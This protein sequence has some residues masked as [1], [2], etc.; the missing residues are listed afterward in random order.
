MPKRTPKKDQPED[1][2]DRQANG[3]V[4]SD[5]PVAPSSLWLRYVGDGFIE[6]VPAQDHEAPTLED[7]RARVASGLYDFADPTFAA[8][9][10]RLADAMKAEANAKAADQAQQEAAEA[11]RAARAAA[12]QAE[13]RRRQADAA[14]GR[15]QT[16]L[17]RVR[18]AAPPMPSEGTLVTPSDTDNEGG[19][20]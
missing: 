13:D 14:V 15:A 9:R 17:D 18:A 4:A 19:N 10:Q 2:G 8:E 1:A 20:D 11:D 12:E 7:A 6:G 3:Q 5:A 16:T